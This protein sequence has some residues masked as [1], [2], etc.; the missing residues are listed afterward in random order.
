VFGNAGGSVYPPTRRVRE[1]LAAQLAAPVAFVD[2]VEGMYADG[3]RTFVEVGAGTALTG[4]V[5]QILGDR[6]HLAVPLDRRGRHGLTSLQ[7]GLGRLAVHGVALDLAPLTVDVVP[8]PTPTPLSKSA[9]RLD[10]GN[11]GRPYPRRNR[12][13]TVHPRPPP[14]RPPRPARPVPRARCGAVPQRWRVVHC[15]YEV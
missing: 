7:E 11:Y 3:V 5:G 13:P 8:A 9:V 6:P 15:G 1:R 2:V 10:G 14:R 4:L 12:C